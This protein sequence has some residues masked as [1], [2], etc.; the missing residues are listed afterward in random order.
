VKLSILVS[1]DNEVSIV[2]GNALLGGATTPNL[3]ANVMSIQE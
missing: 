2:E 1:N 3:Q